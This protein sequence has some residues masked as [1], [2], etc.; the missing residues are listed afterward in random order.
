GHPPTRR[1]GRPA[2]P[3]TCDLAAP[4][5][6][7]IPGPMG[8]CRPPLRPPRYPRHG[9]R[10][11]ARQSL[12][13]KPLRP[14]QPR[15]GPPPAGAPARHADAPLLASDRR[16]GQLVTAAGGCTAMLLN[17]GV[18]RAP[19]F[20]FADLADAGAFVAWALTQLDAFRDQA[21][22]TTRHGRLSDTRITV[23]G[24]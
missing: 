2:T 21:A 15:R 8:L 4:I 20:A 22:R 23:E 16:A 17:E 11:A 19:G 10:L 13:G 12:P 7:S 1:C 3:D 6:L 9:G 14:A 18:G 5:I 24:N